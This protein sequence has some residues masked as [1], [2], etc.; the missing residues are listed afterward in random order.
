MKTDEM[1]YSVCKQLLVLTYFAY[2]M[3]WFYIISTATVVS[4]RFIT[5]CLAFFNLLGTGTKPKCLQ[6]EP[7]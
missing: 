6:K 2:L 5:T 4:L 1:A 3:V 7:F